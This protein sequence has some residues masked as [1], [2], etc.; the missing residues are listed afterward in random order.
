MNTPSK[1]VL[2]ATLFGALAADEVTGH[3]RYHVY[4]NAPDSGVQVP[5]VRGTATETRS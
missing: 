5:V 3:G 2:Y 4:V 1:F